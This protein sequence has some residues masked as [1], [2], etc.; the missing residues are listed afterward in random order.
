MLEELIE[1]SRE[2]SMRGESNTHFHIPLHG[3][4]SNLV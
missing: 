3:D 2:E 1:E 4:N